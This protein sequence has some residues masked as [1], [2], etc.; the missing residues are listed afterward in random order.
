MRFSPP[1]FNEANIH[2]VT[3]APPLLP[4]RHANAL[5][6]F[7][8]QD[9]PM[10]DAGMT[11]LAL[12]VDLLVKTLPIH[13][14]QTVVRVNKQLNQ[15]GL[16][17]VQHVTV[18]GV[19][20]VQGLQ[21]CLVVTFDED[22]VAVEVLLPALYEHVGCGGRIALLT[23]CVRNYRGQLYP[24]DDS[25]DQNANDNTYVDDIR[26]V[27]GRIYPPQIS[28]TLSCMC[29]INH[30]ETPWDV[31]WRQDMDGLFIHMFSAV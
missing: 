22:K 26:V 30:S 10:P 24:L 19:G 5:C 17:L 20:D 3:D 11:L 28:I 12:P 21:G 14:L 8:P 13:A 4:A 2:H 27:Q 31:G 9:M 25:F 23:V 1:S 29:A 16:D 7:S 15:I 6:L 18:Q